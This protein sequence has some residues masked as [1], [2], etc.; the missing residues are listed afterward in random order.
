MFVPRK[1]IASDVRK[2]RGREKRRS[3]FADNLERH[4]TGRISH[5]ESCGRSVHLEPVKR[6]QCQTAGYRTRS[7]VP[8]TE[9]KLSLLYS[10]RC[11]FCGRTVLASNLGPDDKAELQYGL[12]N[13]R[14]GRYPLIAGIPVFK[15]GLVGSRGET[16]EDITAMITAGDYTEALVAVLLPPPPPSPTLAPAW[17]QNLPALK[18]MWRLK[19]FAHH[20]QA[21]SWHKQAVVFLLE[22]VH[23]QTAC[24]LFDFYFR[25]S[26]AKIEHYNYF[27][28]RFGQPR[29]LVALSL[30]SI[31]GGPG[32]AILDLAC[33]FGHITRSLAVQAGTQ[34][35]IGLDALFPPLYIA[36]Y[37][38]A[39]QA[40]YVCSDTDTPLPFTG[41]L[42]S[43]VF[44][45]DAFHYFANKARCL[46]ELKRVIR[47]E[48]AIILSSVRNAFSKQT[49]ACHALSPQAC[50]DLVDD[51]PHR[52]VS[53]RRVLER[54]LQRRG[55]ALGSQVEL[56]DLVEEP[57]FSLAASRNQAIFRDHTEFASWPHA[58]GRLSVN[59]LYVTERTDHHGTTLFRR[60]F[61]SDF[62]E[63]ENKDCK[64]Y[65]PEAVAVSSHVLQEME[66][67]GSSPEFEQLLAQCVVLGLPERYGRV[68]R[69]QRR[70][71]TL[72]CSRTV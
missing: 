58:Q 38:L 50:S 3:T 70:S 22:A 45:S 48:G 17:I 13:C 8:A 40:D 19:H 67:G 46:R 14:C 31:I 25:C 52:I 21:R 23:R 55:P 34:P 15:K 1:R 16:V 53:D 37:W 32:S 72:D 29:H 66:T 18:G 54:Y 65:L 61:P 42:F 49:H 71:R 63:E 11:P 28:Y 57:T 62:Y 12:L 33:G 69:S 39:P 9:V 36:K 2:R 26:A 27:A 20:W 51:L 24:D 60:I 43:A 6:G 44:C 41:E 35:V 59:P 68:R 30:A 56:A 5:F 47:R 7:K 4:V 10:L 64:S